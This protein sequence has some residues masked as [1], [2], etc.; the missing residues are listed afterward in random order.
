MH[1]SILSEP[2]S[3]NLALGIVMVEI[4]I[5]TAATKRS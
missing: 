1:S 5:R 3:W 4:G 2:V